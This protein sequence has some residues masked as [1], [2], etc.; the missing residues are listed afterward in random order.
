MLL[1]DAFIIDD[2]V[3][4]ADLFEPGAVV[5]GHEHVAGHSN[6]LQARDTALLVSER[7]ISVA[8]RRGGR[9]RYAVALLGGLDHPTERQEP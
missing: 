7:S 3:A 9:W 4:L 5:I 6:V 8:V 1:E 2:R